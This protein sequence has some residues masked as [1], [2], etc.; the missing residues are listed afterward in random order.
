MATRAC[1]ESLNFVAFFAKNRRWHV[2]RKGA[3]RVRT[4]R[5]FETENPALM[6]TK[7][8]S[9][10]K[11]MIATALALSAVGAVSTE[12]AEAR[13]FGRNECLNP[14]AAG[15]RGRQMGIRN[16]QRIFNAVW[17]RLGRTCDRLDQL[18][19]IISETPFSSPMGGA[20]SACFYQ[21]YVD[22][23]WDQLAGAY[24][25]CSVRCFSEGAAIGRISAEG[26]CAASIAVGGLDDPG[27]ISQPPLPFCGQNLVFGCKSEY[28]SAATSEIRGC[29]PFTVGSF[30]LTFDNSVR[31]DCFVPSD[32]PI[33]DRLML[34]DG[35]VINLGGL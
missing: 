2:S 14:S 28:I 12:N 16:A 19:T 35:S 1:K 27:F 13:G 7:T 17:G 33:R 5:C 15:Y 29:Y 30:G 9:L 3:H 10:G 32:I 23:L 22:T 34:A 25:R 4:S 8:L 26:Y 31:Q 21:G 24:D 11:T 6:K 18:G 20:F